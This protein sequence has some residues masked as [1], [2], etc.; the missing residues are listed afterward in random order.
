MKQ[1]EEQIERFKEALFEDSDAADSDSSIGESLTNRGLKRKKNSKSVYYGSMGNSTGTSVDV[2]YYSIGNT[3]RGVISHYRRRS[4]P[5]WLDHDNPYH[6]IN[7]NETMAPLANPQ[8]I[9][10]HPGIAYIFEQNYLDVLAASAHESISSEHKYAAQLQQL[11]SA[12]LGDD[13]SLTEPPHEVFGITVEQCNGLTETVQKALE[14]SRE[15]IRCWSNV[16]MDLLR[17]IRFKE[18]VLTYCQGENYDGMM[19]HED[20]DKDPQKNE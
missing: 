6:N 12:L 7:I 10:T 19:N 13:P 2:D 9:F 20:K 8:N 3:K 15:F 18:K 5:E 17:A 11:F 1:L 16:R 14:K 4:E